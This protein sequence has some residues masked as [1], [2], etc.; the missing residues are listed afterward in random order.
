VGELPSA[1]PVRDEPLDDAGLVR[2]TLDGD[3]AAFD[4]L[5]RRYMRPALAVAWEFT[6]TLED[7]EDVVQDA[8]LRTLRALGTYDARRP[9]PAWFFTIVRNVARNAAAARTVRDGRRTDLEAAEARDAPHPPAHDAAERA[10]LLD[11]LERAMDGLPP[12]QRACFRL[13]G[14]EGFSAAEV[15][16]MLGISE[17][18][19]RVHT[20]RARR[21][22]RSALRF[23]TD[24]V[25]TE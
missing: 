7:A 15:A 3:G 9:F 8:F 22:L 4:A 10:E 12:M 5:V 11:H 16:T 2:R 21:T 23:L 20:H 24:D 18:T 14:A 1:G 19:V 13:C 17:S 25:R 6:T